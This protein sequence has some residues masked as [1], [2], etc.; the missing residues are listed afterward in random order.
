[1]KN[2][3]FYLP[4]MEDQHILEQLSIRR[5]SCLAFI[6]MCE[7][8]LGYTRY[9]SEQEIKFDRKMQLLDHL[10]QLYDEIYSLDEIIRMFKTANAIQIVL[11]NR[12]HDLI[13]RFDFHNDDP[14]SNDD[15]LKCFLNINSNYEYYFH[16]VIISNDFKIT[17]I[18]FVHI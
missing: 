15:A 13:N 14:K 1:M 10:T 18:E 3:H 11:Y 2:F 8:E 5:S 7:L 6:Q 17:T 16:N 12:D 9:M 4:F